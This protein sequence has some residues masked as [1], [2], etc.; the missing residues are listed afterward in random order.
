MGRALEWFRKR[1]R[2]LDHDHGPDEVLDCLLRTWAEVCLGDGCRQ[3]AL[4]WFRERCRREGHDHGSAGEELDCL[5]GVLAGARSA[6][7]ND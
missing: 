7:R 6:P 5:L 3:P 2:R 1:C 4:K